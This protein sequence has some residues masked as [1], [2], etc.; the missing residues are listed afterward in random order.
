MQPRIHLLAP[1]V[2]CTPKLPYSVLQ[3][4]KIIVTCINF[5]VPCYVIH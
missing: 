5:E 1:H 4:L 2:S 3:Y